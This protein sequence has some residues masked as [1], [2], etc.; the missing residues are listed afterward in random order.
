MISPPLRRRLGV[1][2][3]LYLALALLYSIQC[4]LFETSDEAWHIG[5]TVHLARGGGLPVQ[6]PGQITPWRQEGSQPPLYYQILAA[7]TRLLHLPLSDYEAVYIHNPHVNLGNAEMVAN[8]NMALHA[9]DGTFPWHGAWLTLHL[10]RWISVVLGLVTLYAIMRMVLTFFPSRPG[11]ALGAGLLMAANPMFLFVTASVNND[12]LV[13]AT[14]AVG[15]WVLATL[16]RHGFTWSRWLVLGVT[17]GVAALAKLSGLTFWILTAGVVVWLCWRTHDWQRGM[18]GAAVAFALGLTLAAKWFWRNWTLYGDP[19]GLEMMLEIVGRRAV[20]LIDLTSEWEGFRRSFWGVFGGMNIVMP[21]P[22][23]AALDI[24]TALCGLGLAAYAGLG[25]ARRRAVDWPVWT[26]LVG[27]VAIVFI[28]FLRWTSQ[29]LAS[30]GRLLFTAYGPITLLLWVGW[31]TAT[32]WLRSRALRTSWRAAPIGSLL[33]L[34]GLAPSAW[35]APV[36]RPPAPPTAAELAAAVPLTATFG[37]EFQLLGATALPTQLAPGETVTVTLYLEARQPGNRDW[38]L[39]VHLEDNLGFIVAQEDRYP[40]SGLA[41]ARWLQPGQC[42][43]ETIRLPIPPT[44][45]TPAT[46]TVAVGFYDLTTGERLPA[47]GTGVVAAGDAVRFGT[48]ALVTP[49]GAG[50]HKVTY[51][52]GEQ[53]ELT[54]FELTPRQVRPGETVTLTLYWRA[55]RPVERDYTVFTHILQPPQTIWGQQDKQPAPP[56]SQWQ[57]GEEHQEVYT[58]VVKPETPPG[59]YEIELGWYR[60]DTFERLKLPDGTDFLLLNRVRVLP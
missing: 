22:I 23:Y 32:A 44:A 36:Y 14:T 4:P 27:Y 35:I 9:A 48:T 57:P 53:L 46:L 21:A 30:Q 41:S 37:D 13:N 12:V 26:I 2:L 45:M 55:L 20:T 59:I 40:L 49:E 51:R 56:T 54:G 42:W 6:V 7:F 29:T 24:W 19:M 60:P 47:T 50:P 43:Q 31:E 3:V 16:W 25:L 34:A 1:I 11:W 18:A 15:L 5:L 8:R 39:F 28:S 52:F 33:L 58:L 17:L 38:S 10:W